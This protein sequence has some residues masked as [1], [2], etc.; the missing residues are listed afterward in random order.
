MAQAGPTSAPFDY[1]PLAK[2]TGSAAYY[3]L[4]STSCYLWQLAISG[5]QALAFLPCLT[6]AP[7]DIEM[8]RITT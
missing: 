7:G 8:K 2:L 6:I 1:L 3:D 4:I 5:L